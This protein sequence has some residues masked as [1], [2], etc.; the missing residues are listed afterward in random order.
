M[1]I[2]KAVI[3]AIPRFWLETTFLICLNIIVIVIFYT[4]DSILNSLQN[5]IRARRFDENISYP[6]SSAL[7]KDSGESQVQ[8]FD[9]IDDF[10]G[11]FESSVSGH[12][13]FSC[14][15]SVNYVSP[16]TG[17][18]SPQSSQTNYKSIMVKVSHPTLSAI[19]DTMI[20]SPGL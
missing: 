15:V 9:D 1:G 16:S 20:V 5:E 19:T 2:Y 14:S 6:W 13:V 8:Q 4:S 17:F 11:Y 10:N 3:S 7:G 12:P 18:H